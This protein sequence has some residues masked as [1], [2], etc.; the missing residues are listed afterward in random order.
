MIDAGRA[1]LEALEREELVGRVGRCRHD[2][3]TERNRVR[4]D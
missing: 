1:E 2:L 4:L 3:S